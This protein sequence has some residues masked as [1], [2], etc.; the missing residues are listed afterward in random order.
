ME[1]IRKEGNT[2]SLEDIEEAFLERDG[3]ISVI[4]KG[5]K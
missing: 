5:N 2:T 3:T 1:S 4:K